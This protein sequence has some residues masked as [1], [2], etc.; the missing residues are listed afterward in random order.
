MKEYPRDW[1][2][3]RP[4]RLWLAKEKR[5][6][7][8]RYYAFSWSA[9]EGAWAEIQW[10]HAGQAIEVFNTNNGQHIATFAM[11]PGGNVH[12]FVKPDYNV[13]FNPRTGEKR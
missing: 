11:K 6:M 7:R 10:A 2:T 12:R 5:Q 1:S 13:R 9:I 3:L 8:W 4:F